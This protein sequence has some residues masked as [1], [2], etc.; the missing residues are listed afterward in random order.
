M[1]GT[2]VHTRLNGTF[3]IQ[4]DDMV[5]VINLPTQQQVLVF[6]FNKGT[7]T[8]YDSVLKQKITGKRA[9]QK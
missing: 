6:D 8:G 3:E 5:T 4:K 7:F 1:D 2:C 9:Y